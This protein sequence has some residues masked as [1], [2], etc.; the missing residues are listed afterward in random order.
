M[1]LFYLLNILIYIVI[2]KNKFTVKYPDLFLFFV[3]AAY[4][5]YS[6]AIDEK[7]KEN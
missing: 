3:I 6:W 1:H 2:M 7:K 5:L 4:C